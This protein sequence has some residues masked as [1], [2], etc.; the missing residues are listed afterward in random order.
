[1]TQVPYTYEHGFLEF[2]RCG[3]GHSVA[4]TDNDTVQ[5]ALLPTAPLLLMARVTA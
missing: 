2:V 4:A 3:A 1:M 5:S